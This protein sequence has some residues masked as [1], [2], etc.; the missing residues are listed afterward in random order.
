MNLS[1]TRATRKLQI[2]VLSGV[3]HL[4]H[5]KNVSPVEGQTHI[6]FPAFESAVRSD[7]VGTS[8]GIHSSEGRWFPES[9]EIEL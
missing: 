8:S 3:N 6:L 5:F 9:Q 4:A 1:T 2:P 7:R